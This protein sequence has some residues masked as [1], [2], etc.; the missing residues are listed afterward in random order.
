M[1]AGD[2]IAPAAG[3]AGSSGAGAARVRFNPFGAEFR[4]DPYPMYR[5]LREQRPVHRTLGMWVLSR[6]ADVR[7]VLR[8]RTFSAG[9][10]P[11]QISRQ[12][13]RLEV[14]DTGRVERLSLSSLVFTDEPAHGRLR[15]LVNHV[16]TA[17]AIDGL[18]PGIAATADRLLAQAWAEGGV[19]ASVSGGGSGGAEHQG[20]HGEEGGGERG[21]QGRMDAVAGFAAPLPVAVLCDWLGLPA[22]VRPHV[23]GW[24]HDIRFILEPGL[25]RPGDLVRV[26][27]VLDE[28]MAVLGEVIADRRARPG[29]DLISRLLAAR[30]GGQDRLEDAEIA[31]VGVMC[32]VAGL[33]TTTSLLGNTLLALLTHPAQDALMRRRPQLARAAVSEALRY[34]PPLQLTKRLATRDVEIGGERIPAGAEVLL[35]LGATGRDPAVFARPDEFDIT[36]QAREHLAFGHGMHGCLGGALARAQVEIA[37]ECL[38]RRSDLLRLASPAESPATD[39]PA[40]DRPAAGPGTNR[41][42]GPSWQDH[43]F[44]IRGLTSLPVTLRG[45][46]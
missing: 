46:S 19:D 20:E 28:F 36:R 27:E 22:E 14:T 30:T 38:Y 26:R 7:E 21:D 12:A 35:C 34:D 41:G 33:E 24:T 10:I 4:C 17:T 32:F 3:A 13:A 5:Q 15:A 8:D 1:T 44:I 42:E 9:V 40:A 31:Y 11:R 2:L 29:E 37:L 43:S 16:F 6:Y 25:M 45:G 39:R 23:A 18:R